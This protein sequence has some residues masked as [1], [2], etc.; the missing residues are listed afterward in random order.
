MAEVERLRAVPVRVAQ[1]L[2]AALLDE[3]SAVLSVEAGEE[4]AARNLALFKAVPKALAMTCLRKRR[5]ESSELRQLLESAVGSLATRVM[6]VNLGERAVR[7]ACF[8]RL[9]ALHDEVKSH[10]KAEDQELLRSALAPMAWMQEEAAQ[11]ATLAKKRLPTEQEQRAA[12]KSRG[13]GG[14]GGS[15]GGGGY[16][17]GGAT[18]W[19]TSHW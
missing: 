7:N 15:R 10:G 5:A 3:H 4:S 17:R 8:Q 13:G 1:M 18:D 9:T 11:M 12:K 6:T 16:G 2:S 14:Y 19:S